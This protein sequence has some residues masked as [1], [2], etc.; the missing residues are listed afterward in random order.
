MNADEVVEKVLPEGEADYLKYAD[1]AWKIAREKLKEAIL[2]GVLCQPLSPGI[3]GECG[4]E[5][6]EV[7]TCPACGGIR[8]Y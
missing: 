7:H 5:C 3:T 2:S 8:L 1:T 6:Y 4:G